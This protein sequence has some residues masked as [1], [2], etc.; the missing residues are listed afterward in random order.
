M[1]CA[2]CTVNFGAEEERIE[3]SNSFFHEKCFYEGNCKTCKQSIESGYVTALE[4][5]FH[6]ECF[7]CVDCEEKINSSMID[8]NGLP[9]CQSCYEKEVAAE[10]AKKKHV[11]NDTC[12]HKVYDE[13]TCTEC[14]DIILTGDEVTVSDD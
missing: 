1:S 3:S 9:Q 6:K 8:K 12:G 14:G 13:K 5:K 2:T 4:G 11:H 7:K 10:K